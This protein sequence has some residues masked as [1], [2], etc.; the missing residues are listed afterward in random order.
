MSIFVQIDTIIQKLQRY[1]HKVRHRNTPFNLGLFKVRVSNHFAMA[2]DEF[3]TLMFDGG[4]AANENRSVKS[5]TDGSKVSGDDT[6]TKSKDTDAKSSEESEEDD[7][8]NDKEEKK[9]GVTGD[10]AQDYLLGEKLGNNGWESSET[11]DDE[12]ASDTN[13]D[14]SYKPPNSL[15]KRLNDFVQ[16]EPIA[17]NNDVKIEVDSKVEVKVEVRL[18]NKYKVFQKKF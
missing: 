3:R 10:Y 16:V 12:A 17:D 11:T 5:E 6:D 15:I 7:K 18:Y 14:D 8:E 13:T 4:S 9:N 2:K 1:L